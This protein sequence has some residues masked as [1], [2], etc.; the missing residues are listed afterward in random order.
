[1]ATLSTIELAEMFLNMDKQGIKYVMVLDC[2]A[3]E[4]YSLMDL[5][6]DKTIDRKS[7]EYD[8]E[9]ASVLQEKKRYDSH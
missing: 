3:D 6:D 2:A 9:F 1:M 5:M 4:L 7:D 8:A